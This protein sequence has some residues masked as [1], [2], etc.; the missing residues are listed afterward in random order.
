ME[1][2]SVIVPRTEYNEAEK[3]KIEHAG[4]VSLPVFRAV[5]GFFCFLAVVAAIGRIAIRLTLRRRLYL[6][7][8]LLIFAV[9]SLGA[10]T[11]VYFEFSWFIY[12]LNVLKYD[13][14]VM[15]IPSD[16][17]IIMDAQA[18]NYSL[19]ALMWSAI[20]PV[21]L[22]FLVSFRILIRDVSRAIHIWYWCTFAST[23]AVW[24]FMIALPFIQCPY[25]GNDLLLH[26][27]PETPYKKTIAGNWLAFI[28]DAITDIMIVAIPV[29]I[30]R[31]VRIKLQQKLAIASFLCL[32]IVMVITALI[33]VLLSRWKG[34]GDLT[35]T[36][37]LM[38]IEA[39]I[40][41][42]MAS[43]AAYRAVFVEHS[44]QRDSERQQI[45]YQ[46]NR[47]HHIN[48]RKYMLKE[49]PDDSFKGRLKQIRQQQNESDT[50]DV[51]YVSRDEPAGLLA[52]P[53]TGNAAMNTM[54]SFIRGVGQTRRDNNSMDS[55]VGLHS[56]GTTLSNNDT[57]QSR[58]ESQKSLDV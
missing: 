31:H 19:M 45:Q 18:I 21:K 1:N 32:S 39:C 57:L 38:Y 47:I 36:Y 40:A 24:A 14:S 17:K 50:L 33:R 35:L 7:D 9:A 46:E 54:I 55:T 3:Y 27:T 52:R 25:T 10:A 22:C 49:I 2:L 8:F 43:L 13:T 26:C 42:I 53:R 30:L 34:W 16:L 4:R 51:T 28:F 6:D 29:W 20:F 58:G 5:A 48:G 56:F 11:G 15:P 41:V 23:I 44:K 12:I 37:L